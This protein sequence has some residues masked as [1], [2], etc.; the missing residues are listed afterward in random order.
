MYFFSQCCELHPK[1]FMWLKT[2]RQRLESRG[3]RKCWWLEGFGETHCSRHSWAESL[4]LP[5]ATR[6]SPCP[7][8]SLS[9]SFCLSTANNWCYLPVR[10]QH[11][12][13]ASIQH[14]KLSGTEHPQLILQR[15]NKYFLSRF[16]C[17]FN[18]HV[19]FSDLWCTVTGIRYLILSRAAAINSQSSDP[20][21]SSCC[22]W[23]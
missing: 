6:S 15:G 1:V 2:T 22:L 10:L 21:S 3:G 9:M 4:L 23:C 18:S 14:F 13:F 7:G 5:A 17:L 11:P 20:S 19:C 8:R 16:G 12:D